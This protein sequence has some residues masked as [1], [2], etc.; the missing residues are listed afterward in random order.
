ME[1]KQTKKEIEKEKVASTPV[2]EAAVES[3]AEPV[4]EVKEE[5]KEESTELGGLEVGP[6][7]G[8]TWTPRTELGRKVLSG[9]VA[10]IDAIL[11]SG[12]SIME[13]EIVDYLLPGLET[14]L[15]LIGQAKGK[16]GGGQRRAFRQNQKKTSEGNKIHFAALAVVG[17]KNGYVGVGYGKAKETVPA[18]EKALRNARLG[19]FKIRRGAGSWE[20]DSKDPTS[21]PF[22]VT[23]KN[24]AAQLTLFPAPKGTGLIV[25][26]ECSKILK[27]AG[28]QDVRSMVKQPKTKLNILMACVK[29]LR[30]LSTMK[31]READK[32]TLS[33]VSGSGGR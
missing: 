21:I 25:E 30:K 3:V 8:K 10:D 5:P 12:K 24:G 33:I 26:K 23:G 31:V 15:L 27:L 1:I 29:A 2:P 19:I 6:A 4:V 7:R 13:A 17:N 32:E 16:F 22:K 18:R 9:E 20:S 11:D 28:I 14:D